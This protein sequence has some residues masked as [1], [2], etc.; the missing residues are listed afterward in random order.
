[1]KAAKIS[2]WNNKWTDI[3]DFTPNRG[4]GKVNHSVCYDKVMPGFVSTLSDMQKIV[5]AVEK[6]KGSD[7][8]H[9]KEIGEED[10]DAINLDFG[11]GSVEQYLIP[12]SL[13][14]CT[15]RSTEECFILIF[16]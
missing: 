1:M 15:K 5:A 2:Y 7:I 3:F 8:V 4:A 16:L 14:G 12:I 6:R 13:P 11:E 10:L 9:L